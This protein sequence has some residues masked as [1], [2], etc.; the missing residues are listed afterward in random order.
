MERIKAYFKKKYN[1]S[2]YQIAQIIFLFKTLGSELSKIVIMGLLFFNHISHYFFALFIMLFLRCTTGGLHF[3]TYLGCLLT[4]IFYLGMA[5]YVLPHF[6]LPQYIQL[7]LLLLCILLCNYI[8][9][10]TSK[11][12]PK[13]CESRFNK[14]KKIIT[15]FIFIY[16]LILYI[17]PEN[18]YISVGFWVIILH[19]LQLLLAKIRKKGEYTKHG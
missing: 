8:G 15:M 4:S 11:Y 9:P 5:I 13:E 7:L 2:G 18:T 6:I 3:Y 16:A 12:R 14:F 1:L 17:I 10:I 19:S